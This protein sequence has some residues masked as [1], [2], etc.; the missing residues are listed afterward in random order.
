M[1]SV[2]GLKRVGVLRRCE[3][4]AVHTPKASAD[5]Q[6]LDD[7]SSSACIDSASQVQEMFKVTASE[8]QVLGA[9]LSERW[10]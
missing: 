5:Q 6:R 9:G 8:S 4:L 2:C 7:G 1:R 10:F 3:T